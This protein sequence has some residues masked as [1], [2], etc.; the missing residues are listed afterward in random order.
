MTIKL[1]GYFRSSTAYRAR[2]AL[3]LKGIAFESVPVNLLKGEQ[4]SE[5]FLKI[6]PV[7]GVPVLQDGDFILGQSLAIINYIDNLKPE[8]PLAPGDIRDQAFVRQIALTIAEDIHPLINLKVRN[9]ISEKLGAEADA[10]K[11]WTRHWMETGMRAVESLLARY[12]KAGDFV[13]GDRVSIAD[14]CLIPQMYSMRRIGLPLDDYPLCRRIEAHCI[15]LKPFQDA[16][17]E[18]QSD[19]PEDLEQTHGPRS[20]LLRR[21]A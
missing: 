14:I 2:I 17:P 8:P 5:D 16:A 11:E 21:A 18:T 12:G 3:Q 9:Y 19:A 1:Y 15:G 10:Q 7:G 20:P 4:R 13:L 6:N